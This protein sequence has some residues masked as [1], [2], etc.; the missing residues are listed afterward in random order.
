[1]KNDT[2][3][4][5]LAV[6]ILSIAV[7]QTMQISG[8]TNSLIKDVTASGSGSSKAASSPG[9]LDT[10]GW[11]ADEVMNYEM[12]GIIPARASSGGSSSSG[13]SAASAPTMVG[14][15]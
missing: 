13:R 12:H 8:M 10:T 15:C 4:I 9:A 14:G 3:T 5:L 7:I 11:T 6:V 2:I 1:M